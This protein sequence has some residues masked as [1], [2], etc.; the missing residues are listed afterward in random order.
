MIQEIITL[1]IIAGAVGYFVYSMY[2]TF[3][4]KKGKV[5]TM[6]CPGCSSECNL[7]KG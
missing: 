6:G 5:K 1:L 2:R 3:V 7:H 4:P